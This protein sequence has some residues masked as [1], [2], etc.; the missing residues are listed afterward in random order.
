MTALQTGEITWTSADPHLGGN[1]APIGSEVDAADDLGAY[2]V[3]SP[4]RLA[5]VSP[6]ERRDDGPAGRV[7]ARQ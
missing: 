6:D 4:W 5:D 7:P 1:F 3:R 2:P